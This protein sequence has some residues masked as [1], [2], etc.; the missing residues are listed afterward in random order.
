LVVSC[1]LLM[2]SLPCFSSP[3]VGREENACD[4]LIRTNCYCY[5]V[6]KYV[7]S[8]CEPGLGSTGKPFPLP[9]QDCKAAVQVGRAELL[10]L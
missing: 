9:V 6:S 10:P 7:G 3:A 2:L 1:K 5:A 8:Y 4:I